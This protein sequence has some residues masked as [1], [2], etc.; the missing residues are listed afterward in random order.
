MIEKSSAGEGFAPS[1]AGPIWAGSSQSCQP[2]PRFSGRICSRMAPIS[3]RGRYC[4]QR[5]IRLCKATSTTAQMDSR[6]SAGMQPLW[7]Q[8][9]DHT[10]RRHSGAYGM[11]RLNLL[12]WFTRYDVRI[13]IPTLMRAGASRIDRRQVD[14]DAIVINLPSVVCVID[15]RRRHSDLLAV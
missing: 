11:Y 15:R 7:N 13:D 5:P 12:V 1:R 2:W 6:V 8:A 4:G 3:V 9:V 14:K 10:M